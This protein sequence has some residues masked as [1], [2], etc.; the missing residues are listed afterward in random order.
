MEPLLLKRS[1][2]LFVNSTAAH[3]GAA[4]L[5]LHGGAVDF[6]RRPHERAVVQPVFLHQHLRAA[7]RITLVSSCFCYA[8][9]VAVLASECDSRS[10][11]RPIPS[12]SMHYIQACRVEKCQCYDAAAAV[13]IFLNELCGPRQLLLWSHQHV[14]HAQRPIFEPVT[15]RS[16]WDN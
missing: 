13:P 14:D 11:E 9:L 2:Q 7:S 15:Q 6:E 16:I 3:H 10:R 12:C 5:N 8:P 1:E 4:G